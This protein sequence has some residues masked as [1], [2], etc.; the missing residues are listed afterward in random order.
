MLAFVWENLLVPIDPY[1]ITLC[2][3][4]DGLWMY[5]LSGERKTKVDYSIKYAQ[6]NR[7]FI[8]LERMARKKVVGI[9]CTE[10][11]GHVIILFCHI[12]LNNANIIDNLRL[13]LASAQFQFSF[14]SNQQTFLFDYSRCSLLN[15]WFSNLSL[16]RKL[17]YCFYFE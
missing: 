13:L 6:S 3:C 16:F 5:G 9:S 15:Q 4:V 2:V 7:F 14:G 17:F 1:R 11:R 10:G 12:I 8:N